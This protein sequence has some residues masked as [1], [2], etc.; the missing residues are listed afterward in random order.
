[1]ST[2]RFDLDTYQQG[3]QQWSHTDT[4]E[5]V[6]EYSIDKGPVSERPAS[7]DYD[8][9]LYFATDQGLLWRWDETATDWV[10]DAFGTQSN[11]VPNTSHFNAISTEELGTDSGLSDARLPV[12]VQTPVI[13]TWERQESDYLT[14]L[15]DQD[16]FQFDTS[17]Y[18]TDGVSLEATG[19]TAYQTPYV[20][21]RGFK[22]HLYVRHDGD[23]GTSINFILKFGDEQSSGQGDG[24]ECRYR[25]DGTSRIRRVDDGSVTE[26]AG[27]GS[28]GPND[29]W[30]KMTV[31][32]GHE[33][34]EFAVE[35]LDGTEVF[36]ISADDT[37]YQDRFNINI[38]QRA[39]A[40]SMWLDSI[41]RGLIQ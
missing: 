30:L 1:M 25:V 2:P 15:D 29:E 17:E 38:R 4:V 3:D 10:T 24:Y 13:E 28:N 39:D 27:D 5:F 36:T 19:D 32:V 33:P 35:E 16:S 40:D 9:E 7:G 34:I 21:F 20:G 31:S 11:P 41:N 14:I 22:Y 18:L 23:S 8:D 37:T 6:D 12:G 26:L